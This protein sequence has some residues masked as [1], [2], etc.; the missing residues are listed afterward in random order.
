MLL[1][2]AA[3]RAR[4]LNSPSR[5]HVAI[6]ALLAL[7]ERAKL[8]VVRML[9][10][11]C[12]QN[13]PLVYKGWAA[14]CA[15]C[16]KPRAPFSGK[17]LQFAGQP[18]KWGSRLGRALGVMVLGFGLLLALVLILFFQLL[19]PTASIGYALGLPIALISIVVGLV[20]MLT[21]RKLGRVG[22]D[23]E[24]QAR[25]EAL[26]ALAVHRGGMLTAADAA[27]AL[28]IDRGQADAL[29]GELAKAEP[30]QV[31]LEFDDEGQTFYSFVQGPAKPQPF[32]VKYRVDEQGKVRVTDVLG[33][34]AAAEQYADRAPRRSGR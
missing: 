33:A 18:S 29:L 5:K 10:P 28:Q 22:A 26:Y 15:A 14:Y 16:D 31:S 30:E 20:L 3:F 27:H 19:I 34:D 12:R 25:V 2:C 6:C 4:E 17:A 7:L 32:G 21:S 13:A 1:G 11:H 9:C 23:A 24:R 8:F